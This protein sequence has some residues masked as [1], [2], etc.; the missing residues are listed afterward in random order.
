MVNFNTPGE[1]VNILAVQKPIAKLPMQMEI[2]TNDQ[3]PT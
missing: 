1:Q 2:G 3:R